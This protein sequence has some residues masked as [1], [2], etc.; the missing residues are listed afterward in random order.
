MK[1]DY[2]VEVEWLPF[3][4]HPEIPAEGMQLPQHLRA[5][6]GGMSERLKKMTHASGMEMVIPGLIHNSR[7]ALEAS[8]YARI[9]GVHEAFHQ[10]VFRKFYGEGQDI[11]GWNVLKAA[12]KEVGL[13]PEDMQ[14][15]TESGK[16]HAQVN[17]YISQ[18]IARGVNSVPAYIV[19]DKYAIF[20]AQPYYVFQDLMNQLGSNY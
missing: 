1:N 4:L 3:E 12:A 20:G 17:Q 18:A 8:E 14:S 19:E 15:E 2:K 10:V 11:H 9:Q 6:F 16:Y 5:G 13:D 7:R